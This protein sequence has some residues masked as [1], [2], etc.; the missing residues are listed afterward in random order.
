MDPRYAKVFKPGT[1]PGLTYV[2]RQPRTMGYTYEERL[3]Q[4]LSIEGY[5][6]YIIGPSKIGKTVL[7]ENVIGA[8]NMIC[9][10]GNDFVKER[11]FWSGIG[12]KAGISMEAEIS[13]RSDVFSE[14]E[15]KFLS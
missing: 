15:K 1:Y 11:D 3:R 9:M 5:L 8:D 13:E 7:C 4:S 6:T 14:N 12:K 2:T 10:S